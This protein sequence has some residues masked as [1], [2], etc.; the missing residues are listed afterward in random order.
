MQLLQRLSPEEID[1]AVL[2]FAIELAIVMGFSAHGLPLFAHTRCSLRLLM[3]Q[4]TAALIQLRKHP[5]YI[6]ICHVHC[7][8]RH[9]RLL[10]GLKA[11]TCR[12][13]LLLA[14]NL[15]VPTSG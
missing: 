12:D 4:M 2:F 6:Y 14:A 9:A 13:I 11:T 8:A 15:M 10:R 5:I 3:R 7:A 1:H